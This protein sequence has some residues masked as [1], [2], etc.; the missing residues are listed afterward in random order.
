MLGFMADTFIRL[1]F[2]KVGGRLFPVPRAWVCVTVDGRVYERVPAR[3]DRWR[4]RPRRRRVPS[5][6]AD[7]YLAATR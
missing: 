5:G 2:L 3:P 6:S 4:I 7:P 1:R